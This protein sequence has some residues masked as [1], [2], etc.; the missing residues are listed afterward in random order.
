V[1]KRRISVQFRLVGYAAGVLAGA[2]C[3]GSDARAVDLP[4]RRPGLWDV[5]MH[6]AA[7]TMP[8]ITMKFCTD[9]S[10]DAAMYKLGM[11]PGAPPCS[12]KDMQRS[13]NVVTMDSVCQMDASKLTSHIEMTFTGDTAYRTSIKSHYD[14]PLNGQ[15][16]SS[17]SQDAKWIGP[18]P[19]DM[20]PGDMIGPSGIKMNVKSR[21]E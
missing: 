8:P 1:V 19:P 4:A 20:Q 15:R 11:S 7:G 21:A 5:T 17:M 10:V 3:A 16:E 18:C 2:L 9:E 13:G 14:P 6:M 12:R